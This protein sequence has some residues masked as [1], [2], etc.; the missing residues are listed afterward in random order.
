LVAVEGSFRISSG[1]TVNST[2][3]EAV[4]PAWQLDPASCGFIQIANVAGN[5][6][7]GTISTDDSCSWADHWAFYCSNA[8]KLFA[9]A[10]IVEKGLE[11]VARLLPG[12][13]N[14]QLDSDTHG[15]RSWESPWI[16]VGDWGLTR[17]YRIY[18][19]YNTLASLNIIYLNLLISITVKSFT[20]ILYGIICTR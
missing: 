17:I 6:Y 7:Y 9:R 20:A 18:P 4:K 10:R 16:W 3:D 2:T 5:G 14:R 8:L 15:M 19:T 12:T 1:E 11:S 13:N